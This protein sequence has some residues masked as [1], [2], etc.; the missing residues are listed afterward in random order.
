MAGERVV[1]SRLVWTKDLT[2]DH[3]LAHAWESVAPDWIEWARAPGHDSYWRYH[4]DLFLDLLPPPPLKLLDLGCGEGRLPRDLK[5][6]GYD[7]SGVDASPTMVAAALEMDPNGEYRVADAGNTGCADASLDTVV[8]FLSLHDVDDLD[9]AVGEVARVLR[10]DGRLCMA[11]IHPL[12]SA[13]RFD[14]SNP[15][16]Q[17]RLEGPYL[18]PRKYEDTVERGDYRMRFASAHRPFGVYF[19][20]L[21]RHGLLIERLRE[22][23][24]GDP[25]QIL[26][27]GQRYLGVPLFLH[28]R[29]VKHSVA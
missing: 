18:R 14:S 25:S 28:I 27:P 17:F 6:L 2:D 10:P 11:L 3:L 23:P 19:E 12:N 24:D 5:T 13:G 15:D 9:A 26:Q 7:A 8:A 20:S 1:D 22:I 4:R 21:E 16:A 29:A